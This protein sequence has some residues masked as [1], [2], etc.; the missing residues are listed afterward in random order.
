M[1]RLVQRLSVR[2]STVVF[3]TLSTYFGLRP[4]VQGAKRFF[5]QKLK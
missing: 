5:G 2:F 3:D 1:Q 4:G